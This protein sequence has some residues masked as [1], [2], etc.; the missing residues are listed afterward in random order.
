MRKLIIVTLILATKVTVAQTYIS[1]GTGYLFPTGNSQLKSESYDTASVKQSAKITNFS[2]TAGIGI[3]LAFGY[4]LSKNLGIEFNMSSIIG[5]KY[6]STIDYIDLW[7]ATLKVNKQIGNYKAPFSLILI[8]SA[9]FKGNAVKGITP[10]G[11]IGVALL[12]Y[13]KQYYDFTLISSASTAP[14]IYSETETT[15]RLSVGFSGA[16]GVHIPINKK[17]KLGIECSMLS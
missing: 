11:R 5:Q 1:I 4:M 15:N 17:L 14:I 13:S 6:T 3:N 16:L 9:V 12:R 10:Y 7:G 8:P 2:Y